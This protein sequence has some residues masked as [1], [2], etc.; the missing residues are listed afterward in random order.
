M[1]LFLVELILGAIVWGPLA[2]RS[3]RGKGRPFWIGYVVGFF[4]GLIGWVI[5]AVIPPS[6]RVAQHHAIPGPGYDTAGWDRVLF[7]AGELPLEKQVWIRNDLA[8]RQQPGQL[9]AAVVGTQQ[10]QPDVSEPAA[11]LI[12]PNVIVVTRGSGVGESMFLRPGGNHILDAVVGDGGPLE[13]T[14]TNFHIVDLAPR[15]QTLAAIQALRSLPWIPLR[16]LH[17]GSER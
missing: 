3:N 5:M 1:A 15:R 7:D 12:Y 13:L 10:Q 8:S 4:L 14:S 9:M 17:P 2:G 16:E 11:L 6:S